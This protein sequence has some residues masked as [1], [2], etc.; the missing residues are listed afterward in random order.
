MA[1][2]PTALPQGSV[3]RGALLIFLTLGTHPQPFERALDWALAARGDEDLVIQHG[4][5]PPRSGESGVRWI[6]FA[7]YEEM[8]ELI[9]VSSVTVCHAGVGTA[10]TV[11]EAGRRPVL[12]P[13]LSVHGEHVDD[14]QLQIGRELESAGYVVT[15]TRGDALPEAIGKARRMPP[16]P[17][18]PPTALLRAAIEAGG[19]NPHRSREAQLGSTAVPEDKSLSGR[20]GMPPRSHPSG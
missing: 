3:Q 4:S 13:R 17:S 12:L 9:R 16:R 2:S 1:S 8:V 6:E 15:C 18:R 19:G 7:P 5:T 20:A 11:V 10:V 14:H